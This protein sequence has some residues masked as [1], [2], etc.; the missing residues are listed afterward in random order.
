MIGWLDCFVFTQGQPHIHYNRK[1]LNVQ[2]HRRSESL[3]T[4]KVPHTD[5]SSTKE[6]CTGAHTQSVKACCVAL[7]SLSRSTDPSQA[8]RSGRLLIAKQSAIPHKIASNTGPEP[9]LQCV[10]AFLRHMNFKL[11]LQSCFL[12]EMSSVSSHTGA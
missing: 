9:R 11:R 4:R 3:F 12:L 5:W 1:W 6:A 10:C 7:S 2:L 8:L